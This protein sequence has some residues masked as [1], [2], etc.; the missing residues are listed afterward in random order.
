MNRL[1]WWLLL[2]GGA[3]AAAGLLLLLAS[4]LPWLGHLPGDVHYRGRRFALHFPI[5]TCVVLSL[6]L[7]LALNLLLRLF[8]R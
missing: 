3:L 5:A 1:G 7:T 4:R 2:V 6:L 8:R